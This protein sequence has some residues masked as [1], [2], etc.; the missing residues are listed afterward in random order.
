[1]KYVVKKTT[2]LHAA[3]GQLGPNPPILHVNDELEK[4]SDEG[5]PD[6]IKVTGVKGEGFISSDSAT[7][8]GAHPE[9][10]H[11]VFLFGL[12]DA[13]LQLPTGSGTNYQF[14]FT[15]AM[16]ES[17]IKNVPSQPKDS[18]PCGP[19]RYTK[20]RWDELVSKSRAAGDRTNWLD[21][22][23]ISA[24]EASDLE[25]ALQSALGRT[26][27]YNEVYLAHVLAGVNSRMA[28]QVVGAIAATPPPT[29]T[30]DSVLKANGWADADVVG[31][32][33][34]HDKL[35]QDNGK[36][37]TAAKIW[38]AVTAALAPGFNEAAQLGAKFDP[39]DTRTAT[40]S[41][42]KSA[43]GIGA[44]EKKAG[45]ALKILTDKGWTPV[46]VCG[47]LANI[48][49]ESA[50]NEHISGD[51]G[52]AYG[53]CQWHPVRQKLFS[54]HFQKSMLQSTFEEQVAFIDVEL[55]NSEANAGGK[56]KLQT[57]PGPAGRVVSLLY[58]R[59]AG[60]EDEANKRANFA[61]QFAKLLKV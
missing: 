41:G 25:T 44:C 53:L 31:F 46:Q 55:N 49:S 28:V 51:G 38:P 21:Q 15:V 43:A 19:F 36:P 6:W 27:T 34:A 29:M 57:S 4:I 10:D 24:L 37:A 22:A 32:L 1:M 40:S 47:I 30:I 20:A 23:R 26:P 48:Y 11:A 60:G 35:V 54:D 33:A 61:D 45:Q 12:R 39:A 42:G 59:P 16:A 14:L 8:V 17:K 18:D 3:P 50:F 58:E 5:L 13:V 7:P 52:K 2:M 56:L 9:I